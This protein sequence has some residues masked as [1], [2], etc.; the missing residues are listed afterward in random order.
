MFLFI[1]LDYHDLPLIELPLIYLMKIRDLR[2]IT[3]NII[4]PL[5]LNKMNWWVEKSSGNK[6]LKLVSADV[7]ESTLKSRK[8]YGTNSE[9]SLDQ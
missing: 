1:A 6:Y 3:I 8:N 2:H 7:R 9:M 5:Y 4:N